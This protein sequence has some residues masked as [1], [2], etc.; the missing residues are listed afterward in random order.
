MNKEDIVNIIVNTIEDNL[1]ND[2]PKDIPVEAVN[3]FIE[4]GRESLM[5]TA[6]DIADKIL[7]L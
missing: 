2:A 7:A 3:S 4:S 6:S 5:N 1:R